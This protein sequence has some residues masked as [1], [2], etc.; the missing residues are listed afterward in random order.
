MMTAHHFFLVE[1]DLRIIGTRIRLSTQIFQV[2]S[3]FWD[4]GEEVKR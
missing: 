2:A 3:R 1:S 4:L